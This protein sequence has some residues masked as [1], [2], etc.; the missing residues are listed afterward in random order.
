MRRTMRS[1][2]QYILPCALVVGCPGNG[3]NGDDTNPLPVDPPQIDVFTVSP[4][5]VSWDGAATLSWEVTGADRLVVVAVEDGISRCDSDADCV[6]NGD[7]DLGSTVLEPPYL[8]TT[9]R[10]Y[11]F[12]DGGQASQDA[13]VHISP[14]VFGD[15]GMTYNDLAIWRLDHSPASPPYR[16]VVINDTR[17]S[18][19]GCGTDVEQAAFVEL[20]DQIALLDPAPAFVVDIGDLV[21]TGAECQWGLYV[22]TVSQFMETTGIPWISVSGNHEFYAPEGHTQYA[23]WFGDEDFSYD[24]GKTRFIALN[25]THGGDPR[26]EL[27]EIQLEWLRQAIDDAVT[28]QMADVFVMMHIPPRLPARTPMDCGY[29]YNHYDHHFYD[30]RKGFKGADAFL[31]ILEDNAP[32]VTAGLYGHVHSLGIFT[33]HGV[34]QLVTGGGGAELC[35]EGDYHEGDTDHDSPFHDGIGHHFALMTV[36]SDLG[37]DYTGGIVWRGDEAPDPAYSFDHTTDDPHLNLPLPFA[38]RF[39]GVDE[40]LDA[41]AFWTPFHESLDPSSHAQWHLDLEAGTLRQDANFYQGSSTDCT[42]ECLGTQARTWTTDWSD[43]RV[44]VEVVSDDNDA[45]GL[46]FYYQDYDHYYRF[47]VDRQRGY[48]MLSRK[49]AGTTVVELVKESFTPPGAGVP[50]QLAVEVKTN[51]ASTTMEAFV[52]GSSVFTFADDSAERL[53]QGGVGLYTW[54]NAG[55][56]F[57][58]VRVDVITR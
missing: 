7:L 2:V 26:D 17:P 8:A 29:L 37:Q 53:Q 11:A 5:T 32:P 38:A 30:G 47:S 36:Q 48:A 24:V 13:V 34:R 56:A 19:A 39:D 6:I 57:D 23:L 41:W 18:S 25:A 35:S 40:P 16:F 58:D 3:E 14:P 52:D 54:G 45:Y 12:N 9:F 4:N 42:P 1:V 50:V 31:S 22:D 21:N 10:L 55:T 44:E 27:T 51:A 46:L 43:Y 20:R 28:A 33:R 49:G 15:G